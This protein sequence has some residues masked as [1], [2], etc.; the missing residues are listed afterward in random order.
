M[1]VSGAFDAGIAG[2][3]FAVGAGCIHINA[4]QVIRGR[5]AKTSPG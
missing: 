2:F 4:G 3:S 5:I 1:T